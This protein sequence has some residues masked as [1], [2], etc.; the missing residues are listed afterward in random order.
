M[1]VKFGQTRFTHRFLL[2]DV[3]NPILGMDFFTKF[4]LLISPPSHKVLFLSNLDDVLQNTPQGSP[5]SAIKVSP[6]QGPPLLASQ[7][8]AQQVDSTPLPTQ[9]EQLLLEFPGLLNK[10]NGTPHPKHGVEHVI[11]TTGRPV[12]AKARRLDPDKLRTAKDEF[13]KLE[14]AGIIRRSDS[15][16]ASPL[17]MV[18][19]SDGSWRPCG[20]YRR[21]NN[22]TTDDRYPL[23]N[24]QDLSSKLAGCTVFSRLDLVKGYHQVPLAAADVPKTA[25]I[26]PFGLYEYVFMSFGLKNAA[27]SFQRLMDRLLADIPHAFVYLDDILI[28]TPDVASH[29]AALRQVFGVLDSN[30]LTINFGKCDFLKEEIDFL[31]HRVSAAGVTPLGGHVDAIRLVPRPTT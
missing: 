18:K 25:I 17:H 19:K 24:M 14:L 22:I 12:F 11:E 9:V 27:Q 1:Q 3:A 10:G 5:L 2:A 13:R 31:G 15:P 28:G 16:W 21:L 29:L 4:N 23:P 6:P 20:D 7:P 30:G 8:A 26:T